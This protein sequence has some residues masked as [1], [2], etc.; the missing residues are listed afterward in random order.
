MRRHRHS[1]RR[2]AMS[3]SCTGTTMMDHYRSKS[4]QLFM[5]I[6][7]RQKTGHRIWDR[8]VNPCTVQLSQDL[9]TSH[10]YYHIDQ[11]GS[12]SRS[13]HRVRKQKIQTTLSQTSSSTLTAWYGQF[14]HI[15]HCTI[16]TPQNKC[17]KYYWCRPQRRIVRT[18]M[19]ARHVLLSNQINCIRFM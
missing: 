4:I 17:R 3:S 7:N 1:P 8:F 5:K 11:A 14:S 13:R 19:R 9:V 12:W 16:H 6:L 10:V 2:L 18:F 15:T